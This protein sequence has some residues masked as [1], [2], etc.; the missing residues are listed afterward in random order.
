MQD[1][2]SILTKLNGEFF[3]AMQETCLTACRV[4]DITKKSK[5]KLYVLCA[6]S[7]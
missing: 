3:A 4:Q 7:K 2:P 5:D 1:L 6:C